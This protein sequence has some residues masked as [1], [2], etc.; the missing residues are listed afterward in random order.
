VNKILYNATATFTVKCAICYFCVQMGQTYLAPVPGKKM[1][2]L[3][4]AFR[5][6][7][8]AT[9]VIEYSRLAVHSL[10]CFVSILG[11]NL[12]GGKFCA[13]KTDSERQCNCTEV[14]AGL[15]ECSR[16]NFDSLLWA[17]V[18]VFQVCC[19]RNQRTQRKQQ[20]RHI[21]DIANRFKNPIKTHYRNTAKTLFCE[22]AVK[23]KTSKTSEKWWRRHIDKTV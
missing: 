19:L 3:N 14:T 11:M 23:L 4:Y 7:L 20:T 22:F 8:C 2:R 13:L 21:G 18:T 12:F 15:C 6:S 9:P 17:I 10:F 5:N 1:R 16:K